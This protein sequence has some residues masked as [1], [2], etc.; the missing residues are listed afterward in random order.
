MGNDNLVK[1]LY[2]MCLFREAD[3]AGLQHWT[4]ALERGLDFGELMKC[5]LDSEERRQ[6]EAAGGRLFVPPGHFYSPI[7]DT[8]QVTFSS[9]A[10]P[11]RLAGISGSQLT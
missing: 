1:N 3:P 11:H 6:I 8:R 4:Q 5:L 10:T 7:V 9:T 2:R